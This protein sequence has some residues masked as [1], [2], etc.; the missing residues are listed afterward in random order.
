VVIA[1]LAVILTG[2]LLV[3]WLI[4]LAVPVALLLR[5]FA[6][7]RHTMTNAVS[8]LTAEYGQACGMTKALDEF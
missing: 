3:P 1:A 7:S 8:Q 6:A 4:P 2:T 5:K